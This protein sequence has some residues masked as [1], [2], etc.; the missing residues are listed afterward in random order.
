MLLNATPSLCAVC[1]CMHRYTQQRSSGTY[2]VYM[3]KAV[4]RLSVYMC[5]TPNAQAAYEPPQLQLQRM[6]LDEW[7]AVISALQLV[8]TRL[9]SLEG[10][11]HIGTALASVND[12]RIQYLFKL[13]V[14]GRCRHACG[15]VA[16]ACHSLAESIEHPP[17]G[18]MVRA[19]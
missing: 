7:R 6:D 19:S 12:K 2:F 17:R 14:V 16:A 18:A 11:L 10:V 9:A 15:T 3:S 13:D 1:I 4:F 5:T 8:I